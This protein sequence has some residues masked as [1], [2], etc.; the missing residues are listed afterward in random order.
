MNRTIAM[1]AATPRIDTRTALAELSILLEEDELELLLYAVEVTATLLV[2]VDD[3]LVCTL[4]E[5]EVMVWLEPLEEVEP[6][7]ELE[8]E[9]EPDLE[10]ELE[11]DLEL[12]VADDVCT[13]ES[14]ALIEV[15]G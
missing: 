13:D 2:D 9:L 1:N 4:W 10:L 5:V 8:L 6:D 12:D 3:P 7:L 15:E 14:E 11:L